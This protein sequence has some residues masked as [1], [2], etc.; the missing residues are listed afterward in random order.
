MSDD[1]ILAAIPLP[2]P[3][4][5]WIAVRIDRAIVFGVATLVGCA[6]IFLA[7]PGIDLAVSGIFFN[8]T[9]GFPVGQ[10]W[11]GRA[12]RAACITLTDG[13]ILV[14]LALLM[15]SFYWP[16]LR[17]LP[18]REM[19][20]S[21]LTYLMIPGI[22]VNAVI[23]PI[24][25]RARP[26]NIT[27]FGGNL[28]FTA[29]FEVSDQCHSACSFVSGETSALFTVATLLVLLVVPRL[30]PSNREQAIALIALIALSASALRIAFGAHFLSD[31]VF[32][33]LI[34]VVLTLLSYKVL[35]PDIAKQRP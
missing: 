5:P 4:P 11:L 24:W 2:R 32:A 6:L 8:P 33:A 34:S 29:P 17:D 21:V 35:R 16:P 28:R 30:P 20:F 23:K 7:F 31:V 14:T 15:G 9:L 25:G 22:L 26:I 18:R 10:A 1:D 13:T 19:A 27:E 3:A 12:A